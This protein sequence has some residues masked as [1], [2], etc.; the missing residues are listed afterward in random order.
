MRRATVAMV[1]AVVAAGCGLMP[2]GCPTS[3]KEAEDSAAIGADTMI[4]TGHVIRYVPAPE[5]PAARGYD[6][7]IV[8]W[9]IGRPDPEGVFLRVDEA[10]PGVAPGD[11]VLIVA[12]PGSRPNVIVA[13]PCPPLVPIRGADV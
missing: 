1:L 13:G 8:R 10:V 3:V 7:N 4:F 9:L 11:P 5:A 2:S 12:E 6:L